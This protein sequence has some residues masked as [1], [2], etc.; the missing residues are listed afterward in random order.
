MKILLYLHPLRLMMLFMVLPFLV[1]CVAVNPTMTEWEYLVPEGYQGFLVIRYHCPGGI[2]L[3]R[4]DTRIIVQYDADG[5]FCTNEAPFHTFG[6]VP[7][8]ITSSG[9]SIPYVTDSYTYSGWGVCCGHSQ[10]IGGGTIENPGSDLILDIQWV[11]ILSPR[12]STAPE[13]PDNFERYW[14][15]RF[16]FNELTPTPQFCR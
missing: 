1:N 7:R 4:K 8:T 13:F 2:P 10:A 5:V 12:P 15:C 11:G 16:L 6:T 14:K 3:P 9:R